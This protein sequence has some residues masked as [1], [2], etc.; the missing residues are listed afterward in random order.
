[1][2]NNFLKTVAYLALI[3]ARNGELKL[4]SF[5]SS[6]GNC[7]ALGCAEFSRLHA[8]N[9]V[10][11]ITPP[12]PPTPLLILTQIDDQASKKS[13]VNQNISSFLRNEAY[14]LMENTKMCFF[15]VYL[16]LFYA[17]ALI[18]P[19]NKLFKGGFL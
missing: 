5:C 16:A 15:G 1:V 9:G 11:Y 10:L 2:I 14:F 8:L 12:P 17:S 6:W 3:A 4:A 13:I 19:E 18:F 7:S